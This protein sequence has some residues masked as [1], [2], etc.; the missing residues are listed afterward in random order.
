MSSISKFAENKK[1]AD[2][3]GLKMAYCEQ[4]EGDAILFLHGNPTSSFLWRDIV[5]H[6]SDLGRCISPDLIGMGDSDKLPN[7]GPGSYRLVEHR[8]YLDALIEQLNVGNQVVLVI[9]DWGSALGFDWARRHQGRVKGVC[10]MEGF[11][12]PVFWAEWPEAARR[13]FQGFRS[14]AGEEMVLEK[15][16][17]VERVL[18][19]SILRT[20]SDEEMAEYR[21]PFSNVGEDRRPTLTWPREIPIEGEPEDV[22]KIVEAYARYFS[23]SDMP[24]LLISADPGAILTGKQLEFCRAWRNQ[25]EVTVRGNHFIQEDSAD[26]IGRA[27]RNWL[28]KIG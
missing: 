21:R 17:F 4:G 12:R 26:E 15:N 5:P 16:I 10:Y 7:S 3:K 9:H 20:L 28:M 6:V 1:S 25:T 24:K 2:V 11:V 13:V 19:G 18:P 14:P 8:E 23:A 27:L 22:V